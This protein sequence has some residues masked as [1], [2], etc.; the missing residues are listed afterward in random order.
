MSFPRQDEVNDR[1]I[2][3][4]FVGSSVRP[5]KEDSVGINTNAPIRDEVRPLWMKKKR[6]LGSGRTE[7]EAE[8]PKLLLTLGNQTILGQGVYGAIGLVFPPPKM[9]KALMLTCSTRVR[10]NAKRP[11]LPFLST[12]VLP[13][14]FGLH[15]F[16]ESRRTL[17][18][19]GW[20]VAAGHFAATR[21]S[22]WGIR[23]PNALRSQESDGSS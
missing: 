19:G 21:N 4:E 6:N 2:E 16:L 11:F 23:S 3:E 13:L 12:Q 7:E 9:A 18:P 14:P 22:I 15:P 10:K 1:S 8:A 5:A 17:P 20:P